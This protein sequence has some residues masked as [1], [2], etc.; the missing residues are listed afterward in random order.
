MA[1]EKVLDPV[2]AFLQKR[3][4]QGTGEAPGSSGD[5]SARLGT[6]IE[7]LGNT[8]RPLRRPIATSRSIAAGQTLDSIRWGPNEAS[9][10]DVL[11]LCASLVSGQTVVPKVQ[12]TIKCGA[13]HSD[14]DFSFTVDVGLGTAIRLPADRGEVKF[15]NLDSGGAVMCGA[16]LSRGSTT[17]LPKN[18]QVFTSLADAGTS[19][20]TI[21]NFAYQVRP[22]IHFPNPGVVWLVQKDGAGNSLTLSEWDQTDTG[23]GE[24]LRP[25]ARSV[26]IT[27]R[28]GATIDYGALTFVL[29]V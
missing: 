7:L 19:L 5:L 27:N 15:T 10:Y 9:F 1:E 14:V 29:S 22:Y 11:V 6:L 3:R 21:P 4:E 12:A 23:A 26:E 18:T 28:T 20:I 8:G 16:M 17:D 24:L 25:D 13:D 2:A